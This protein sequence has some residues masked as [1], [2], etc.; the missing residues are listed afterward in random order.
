MVA[1]GGRIDTNKNFRTKKVVNIGTLEQLQD[2]NHFLGNSKGEEGQLDEETRSEPILSFLGLSF[3]IFGGLRDPSCLFCTAG[4][5][6][7]KQRMS[8][9]VSGNQKFRGELKGQRALGGY[10]TWRKTVY[11][12][13]EP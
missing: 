13:T 1:K 10:L 6:F 7:Y 9:A 4:A 11:L 2:M 5:E 12:K 3:P 8:Q